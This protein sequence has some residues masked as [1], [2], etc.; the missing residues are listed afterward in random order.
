MQAFCATLPY[1]VPASWST[2][3]PGALQRW[4]PKF[5]LSTVP[6]VPL[7][8]LPVPADAHAAPISAGM[9]VRSVPGAA[10]SAAGAAGAA[11]KVRAAI[12]TAAAAAAVTVSTSTSPEAV[13]AQTAP[14]AK[15][16]S[17]LERVRCVR[18][19]DAVCTVGGPDALSSPGASLQIRAKER[20]QAA[21]A[22]HGIS[23]VQQQRALLL[24]RLPNLVDAA[25]LYVCVRCTA[26]AL[27][28]PPW[29]N[30]AILASLGARLYTTE[31]RKTLYEENL[32][33]RLAEN[34]HT[35]LS[36]GTP[37]SEGEGRTRSKGGGGRTR[38]KGGPRGERG[39]RAGLGRNAERGRGANAEQER[40]WA[41]TRSQGGLAAAAAAD[42]AGR[43]WGHGDANTAEVRAHLDLLLEVAPGWLV[44]T[45]VAGGHNAVYRLAGTIAVADVKA[46]IATAHAHATH[47]RPL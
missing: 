5:D 22:M 3:G 12:T 46:R 34:H 39:A 36:L 38:S 24:S 20:Q 47:H 43:A 28:R 13:P 32:L 16:G 29:P 30:P 10:P 15:A 14:P 17:L 9:L 37:R 44:R 45:D 23:P 41:R 40:A 26:H 6:P 33:A 27:R 42:V 1:D 25:L 19:G 35:R 2:A 11:A 18:G 8:P 4:H 31:G 21:D 7:A